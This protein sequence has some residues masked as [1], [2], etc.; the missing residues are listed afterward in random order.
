MV[1]QKNSL[2]NLSQEL[3]EQIS[4]ISIYSGALNT[5]CIIECVAKIKKAFPALPIDFYEVFRERIRNTNFSDKRLVDA[6][7]FVIDNCIYPTPT[8]AN[9]ISFDK[10][11]KIYTYEKMLK[12][13]DD[14]GNDSKFWDS[15][16]S[17]LLPNYKER[18]WIHVNDIVMYK[19]QYD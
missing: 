18:I 3:R 6:V 4:E 7:N 14:Y 10:K 5:Q 13:L 16:K 1:Q 19:I 15:Y 11:Y 12:K 17:V 8:I 9:F 2:Q